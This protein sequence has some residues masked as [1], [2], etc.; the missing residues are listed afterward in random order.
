M[1]DFETLEFTRDGDVARLRLNRP[2]L[3]NAFSIRMWD[4]MRELGDAVRDDPDIRV[5]VV[6]GNG[7]AF[8]SGID[9]TV[10]TSGGGLSEPEAGTARH[11]DPAV[12]AI[13]RAQDSYT[14][15]E[16]AR[17]PTIAAVHGYALGAGLQLALA[18]DIRI[19][20]RGTVVGLLEHRYGILPDLGGTQ[21]LPRVVGA[22]KA[23]ELIW[24]A[25]R[26]DAEESYR[27]GLC[28]QLVDADALT[29]AADALASLIAAQPPLAVQGAKRAVAAA[30]RLPVREGLVVEAEAQG[31]CLRSADMREAIA[32]VVEQRP[33]RYEGR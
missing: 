8:S 21:R 10:F 23:K 31:P 26:I 14:W 2:D 15:L 7:R 6:S 29:G 25:A 27:I 17:Y 18:C 22:G 11:E 13:L 9:T 19:F 4:E 3:L 24:T 1:A 16:E 33:P 12:A 32:A 5:L 20:A 28:E 30:D